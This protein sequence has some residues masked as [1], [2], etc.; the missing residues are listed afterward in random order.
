MA[1][2]Y[3]VFIAILASTLTGWVLFFNL[4]PKFDEKIDELIASGKWKEKSLATFIKIISFRK[5]DQFNYYII[6]SIFFAN[7]LV[8]L[9]GLLLKSDFLLLLSVILFNAL[10]IYLFILGYFF[11][12]IYSHS[13]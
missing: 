2:D 13:L 1:A 12:K 5:D 9:W 4:I 10:I 7:M 8:N 6:H 11:I 3:P